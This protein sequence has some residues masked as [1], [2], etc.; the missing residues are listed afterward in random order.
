[1][2]LVSNSGSLNIACWASRKNLLDPLRSI[3]DVAK[4][5][6]LFGTVEGGVICSQR[7]VFSWLLRIAHQLTSR[8]LSGLWPIRTILSQ[9]I[10]LI[11]HMTVAIMNPWTIEEIF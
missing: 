5:S 1:V 2:L 10:P 11:T 6:R 7:M 9:G 3:E 4:G 8:R